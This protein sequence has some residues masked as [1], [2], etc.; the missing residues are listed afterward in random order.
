MALQP[1]D[2]GLAPGAAREPAQDAPHLDPL[3]GTTPARSRLRTTTSP[4]TARAPA[5]ASR[6]DTSTRATGTPTDPGP[7]VPDAGQ[8]P[9]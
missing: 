4:S 7:G 5:P 9:R 3:P 8:R 2:H 1:V 6:V